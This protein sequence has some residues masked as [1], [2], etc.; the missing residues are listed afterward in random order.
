MQWI[1]Q[2]IL[3]NAAQ[4]PSF[5]AR[6][7]PAGS[8]AEILHAAELEPWEM[9]ERE[10]DLTSQTHLVS[11][12]L[13][14]HHGQVRYVLQ[15]TVTP[16]EEGKDSLQLF[17]INSKSAFIKKEFKFTVTGFGF[18][19]A[20]QDG[21]NIQRRLKEGFGYCFVKHLVS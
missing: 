11:E 15:G 9:L 4:L 18:P 19:P 6:A 20:E 14:L 12:R 13:A 2:P 16:P 7:R 3:E 8:T 10:K 17:K 1:P 5:P 21:R